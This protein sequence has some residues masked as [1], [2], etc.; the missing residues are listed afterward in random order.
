MPSSSATLSLEEYLLELASTSVGDLTYEEFAL[1]TDRLRLDPVLVKQRAVFRHE[2]YARNLV[3]LTP[4]FELLLLCW[5]PGQATVVHDHGDA[6]NR[7]R[8]MSGTLTSRVFV[9]SA[10]GPEGPDHPRLGSGPLDMSAEGLFT[11]GMRTGLD[12]RLI[13]QLA[14]TSRERLVTLHVY[15]PPLLDVV[16]YDRETGDTRPVALRYT[17]AADPT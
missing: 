16:A 14:N 11:A 12:R 13:H 17:Q 15:A 3:C 1:L 7:I 2:A 5:E 9:R 6:L 4:Q 8:V 10:P